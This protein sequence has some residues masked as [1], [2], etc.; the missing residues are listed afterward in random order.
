MECAKI[1]DRLHFDFHLVVA[2]LLRT[3]WSSKSAPE[4]LRKCAKKLTR[5]DDVYEPWAIFVGAVE[6]VHAHGLVIEHNNDPL[7]RFVIR[8]LTREGPRDDDLDEGQITKRLLDLGV[9]VDKAT[10]VAATE[11][12]LWGC[13]GVLAEKLRS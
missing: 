11:G 5:D 8:Q 2:I 6:A 4:F 9:S 13:V 1:I 3:G 10:V 12:N 7:L